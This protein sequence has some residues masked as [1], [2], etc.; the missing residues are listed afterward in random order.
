MKTLFAKLLGRYLKGKIV[1]E[2]GPMDDKKKWWKSRSIWTG[3][4][5]VVIAG[6]N[7]ASSSFG[8]PPVPEWV[9]AILGTLGIYTRVTTTTKIG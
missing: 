3:V 2:E 8:L 5:A 7:A 6:Y 1:L 9:F 4:V